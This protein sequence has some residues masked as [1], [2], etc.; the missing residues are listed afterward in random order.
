MPADFPSTPTSI[1]KTSIGIGAIDEIHPPDRLL[2]RYAA[3]EV[4]P[5]RK[6]KLSLHL[7]SCIECRREVSRLRE[8]SRRFRDFE[9]QA[10]LSERST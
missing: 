6:K 1:A 8:I 10:I 9:R 2:G 4:G 5:Q 3:N 7:E